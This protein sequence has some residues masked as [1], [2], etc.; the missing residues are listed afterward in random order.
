MKVIVIGAGLI[1]ISS[2]YFLAKEGY[3]VTVIEKNSKPGMGTSYAN[4]GQISACYSEPWAS[5]SNLKKMISWMT[6]E[7]S[8][9]LFKPNLDLNQWHYALQFLYQALPFNNRKNIKELLGLSLYSRN[10]LQELRDDLGDRLQYNY[11]TSGIATI[12][13]STK[14][15]EMG[16]QSAQFM[17]Q[18]GC[19]R[20]IK[21]KEETIELLPDLNEQLI[22]HGSDYSPEDETGDALLYCSELEKVCLD[23]GVKFIY[24]HEALQFYFADD[25]NIREVY[26]HPT[27]KENETFSNDKVIFLDA[28]A[29]VLATATS[30]FKL[31]D[32]IGVKPL[33]YPV[34]GY[35]A[36][37]DILDHSLITDVSITDSENKMVFTK[38]GNKLRIAGTAEFN[39]YDLSLNPVRCNA[40]VNRAK[41]L[42]KPGA[43]DY[44]STVFWT[45]LRPTTPSS[46]PVIKKTSYENLFLNVG[47]GTL[48]F[49]MAAGS[50]RILT[51]IIKKYF[52]G[53]N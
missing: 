40:L 42:F 27:L 26:I 2:A 43:L 47:H 32:P 19:H 45:G 39:G 28:H 13:T 29:F 7:S 53:E 20:I 30:T 21:N 3:E 15:F 34:K 4:G 17:S 5:I 49:T 46:V 23:M 33:I 24:D 22:I 50:G 9:I 16:K 41:Q 12:Y 8:P 52:N 10:T 48:G 1:G 38:L 18:F 14:D 44:D 6:I 36:T 11:N 25:E 37:I 51:Q 35:S 31:G